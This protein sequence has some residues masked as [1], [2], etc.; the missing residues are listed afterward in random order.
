MTRYG[1]PWTEEQVLGGEEVD[2]VGFDSGTSWWSEQGACVIASSSATITAIG[3]G[4]FTPTILS[5]GETYIFKY[6]VLSNSGFV[7][8]LNKTINPNVTLPSTVG[9]HTIAVPWESNE[10]YDKLFITVLSG[11]GTIVLGSASVKEVITAGNEFKRLDYADFLAIKPY[12][13]GVVPKFDKPDEA[14]LVK[15]VATWPN[16]QTYTQE[17]FDVTEEW[18]TELTDQCGAAP[19]LWIPLIDNEGNIMTDNGNEMGYYR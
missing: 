13:G 17:E 9:V 4:S 2:D 10:T 8:G 7:I 14:C 1:S 12:V 3:A 18:R 5:S 11:S 19:A 16:N 6:E 15:E